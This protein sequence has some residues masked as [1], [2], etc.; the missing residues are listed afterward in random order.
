ML[1]SMLCMCGCFCTG[2][3]LRTLVCVQPASTHTLACRPFT[4]RYTLWVCTMQACVCALLYKHAPAHLGLYTAYAHTHTHWIETHSILVY[5]INTCTTKNIVSVWVFLYRHAPAY[6]G[7][8][9]ADTHTLPLCILCCTL[10]C[11]YWLSVNI[12]YTACQNHYAT[13]LLR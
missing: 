2:T 11:S 3:R 8:C 12:T 6:L 13:L 9:T 1:R 4:H 7:L 5:L 10:L